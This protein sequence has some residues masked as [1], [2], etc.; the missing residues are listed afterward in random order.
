ML[1]RIGAVI[2]AV[3]VLLFAI[4]IR[5]NRSVDRDGSSSD[6]DSAYDVFDDDSVRVVCAEEL[7]EICLS[8]LTI[9]GFQVSV[10]P[11]WTT[12][13]RLADGGRLGANAWLTFRPFDTLLLDPPTPPPQVAAFSPLVLT[14]P[15]SAI[16]ALDA[17]CPEDAT[18]FACAAQRPTSLVLNDPGSSAIGAM[19]LA[20]LAHSSGVAA[21]ATTVA[22][23]TLR[24]SLRAL[25]SSARRSL[26]PALDA[27]R[28]G[29]EQVALTIEAEV[30]SVVEDIDF[31]D[32]ETFDEIG[33]RYPIDVR[34]VEV[35]LVGAPGYLRAADLAAV[36]TSREFGYSFSKLGY[37]TPDR[38]FFLDYVSIFQ[39]RPPVRTD[40]SFDLALLQELRGLG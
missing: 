29:G 20:V 4:G 34:A 27:K 12:A 23:P 22:D 6:P 26:S 15:R 8:D 25:K 39:N 38:P 3:F 5:E 31:E 11:V 18:R 14:G 7:R 16:A 17:A 9:F 1:R 40:L 24:T 37:E 10:E 32:R 2:F 19:A 21:D 35:V 33:V 36:S 28:L 30:V 13:A